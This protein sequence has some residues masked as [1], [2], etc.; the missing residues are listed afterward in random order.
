MDL[1]SGKLAGNVKRI[2][3]L[4]IH[5]LIFYMG[6]ILAK[7]GMA[8]CKVTM[9]QTST[10]LKLPIGLVYGALPILGILILIYEIESIWSILAG[11]SDG[12]GEI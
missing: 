3:N 4:A 5:L 10:A 8:L 11:Y 1:F 2:Y 12:K 7:Y 9:R 6:I